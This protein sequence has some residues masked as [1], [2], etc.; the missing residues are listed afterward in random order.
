[1]FSISFSIAK[2]I[3]IG[4]GLSDNSPYVIGNELEVKNEKPGIYIELMKEVSK[5]IN[6]EF[7]FIRLPW[8]R[9]LQEARAGRIDSVLGSSFNKERNIDNVY[10]MLNG[11]PDKTKSIGLRSY[12]LY[13]K[14]NN[15]LLWD[16]YK[17]SKSNKEIGV[18][19]GYAIVN[20]LKKMEVNFTEL[21]N[22]IQLLEMLQRNR[23]GGFI[24]FD[25]YIDDK[26]SEYPEI[27]KVYPP[28]ITKYYY[29]MFNKKFAGHN[30]SIINKIWEG[31]EKTKKSK[32][33]S[34]ILK[35]YKM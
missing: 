2:P 20:D 27:T 21:N 31:I 15:V 25:S 16:G 7:K 14:I 12:Y 9:L 30:I 13:Q 29:I 1:L 33:Y 28:I 5:N 8:K 19:R 26:L 22:S 11:K 18:I 35:A 24:N 6:I 10:P 34:D 17:I 4:I 32:V 3:I 23:L